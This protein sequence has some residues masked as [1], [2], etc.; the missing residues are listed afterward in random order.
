MSKCAFA[1]DDQCL[2][3][4]SM[5][6]CSHTI[7]LAI[8]TDS[9]RDLLKWYRCRKFTPNFTALSEAGKPKSAG[10]KPAR[11][12]I[13]KKCSKEISTIVREAEMSNVEWEYR[14]DDIEPSECALDTPSP[15]GIPTPAIS[16]YLG[17][18]PTTTTAY[19]VSN[20]DVNI[21]SI[22]T[23]HRQ[24]APPPL[25]PTYLSPP[26]V[27]ASSLPFVSSPC[28]MHSP[29]KRPPVE[30]PFWIA[31]IFGNVSRCQGCKGR[32]ARGENKTL[33]PPPNDI[34]LGH[35]E[36]VVYQNAR[37]G[38]FEQSADKRNVYYHPWRTCVVPHFAHFNAIQHIH[39]PPTVMPKL[40][41]QHK[42]LIASEF[43]LSIP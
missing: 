21:G 9:V 7:A 1:C 6:L 17:T 13:S 42:A 27:S 11:K 23:V 43:G 19:L 41:P 5:K 31:F 38:L 28:A 14:G 25:I 15:R 40:L 22:G 36:H 16:T 3:Y 2:S 12:G 35:K 26:H 20:R 8:K 39:T 37:S 30:T 34:V 24:G 33:L 18:T 4:K 32:I 10:K 29:S